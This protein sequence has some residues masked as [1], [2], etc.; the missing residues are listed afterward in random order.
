MVPGLIAAA[1][2]GDA[3][4]SPGDRATEEYFSSEVA[5][6]DEDW[7]NFGTADDLPPRD[8]RESGP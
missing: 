8:E 6:W 1:I 4:A 2:S 3:N 7:E 5:P